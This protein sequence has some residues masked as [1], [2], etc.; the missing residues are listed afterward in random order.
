MMVTGHASLLLVLA[1]PPTPPAGRSTPPPPPT[2]HFHRIVRFTTYAPWQEHAATLRSSLSGLPGG[3][4]HHARVIERRNAAAA[5]PTDFLLVDFTPAAEGEPAPGDPGGPPPSSAPS[6]ALPPP[7]LRRALRAVG[8]HDAVAGVHA[9]RSYTSRSRRHLCFADHG[10][11]EAAAGAGGGAAWGHHQG[12]NTTASPAAPDERVGE[13]AEEG[14]RRR[15]RAQSYSRDRS[16]ASH[17]NARVQWSEGHKGGGV[18]IALLDSG[19]PAA[20]KGFGPGVIF[21]RTDW[22]EDGIEDDLVGHGTF[23][24]GVMAGNSP[25][26]MGFAPEAHLHSFRVFNRMHHAYTSWFIDAMNYAMVVGVHIVNLSVGGPD[27]MDRPFVDKVIE[28]SANGVI[29]VS[30]NGNDGPHWG[31]TVNP[32][33]MLSVIGVGG[34]AG[35]QYISAFSSRGMTKHELRSGG[36]GR[37]K[38]DLL[39]FAERVHGPSQLGGCTKHSGTSVASPIVAGTVALLA[40]TVPAAKRWQTFNPGVAKQ[41]LIEGATPGQNKLFEEGAGLMDLQASAA[42]LG[43]YEPRASLFPAALDWTESP[44]IHS[45][46]WCTQPLF[47]GAFPTIVNVTLISG[48]AVRSVVTSAPRWHGTSNGDKVVVDCSAYS[49]VLW[50]WSGWLG[51]KLSVPSAA[52]SW[53]GTV[54]GTIILTVSGRPLLPPGI[55]GGGGGG[56]TSEIETVHSEIGL[57]IKISVVAT[58]ARE[59]RILWDQVHSISF[60]PAFIPKDSFEQTH[61]FLDWHA[62][63]PH[64]NFKVKTQSMLA[65][66]PPQ[67]RS[68]AV[69]W[70]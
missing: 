36:Y 48:I 66:P 40:S 44:C 61:D 23:V 46:P 20:H 37:V 59:R 50:P 11:A 54:E 52:A 53:S 29:V 34:A 63:H 9:Q 58:P 13:A 41:I 8:A 22:T 19:M 69:P 70:C 47:H 57:P 7:R 62:D 26:C 10:A 38:P 3:A 14:G 21:E 4:A 49:A 35:N 15:R 45:W 30:A 16:M 43:K 24:G 42:L 32:A 6:L 27:W 51:I 55:G 25:E 68:A 39:T 64:T 31:T 17:F 60:P 56:G 1:L 2:S 5:H 67:L 18:H 12:A 28:L 65:L 33:D